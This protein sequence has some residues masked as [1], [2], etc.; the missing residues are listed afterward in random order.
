MLRLPALCLTL[1]LSFAS[2]V[3]S[4][5]ILSMEDK[6]AA[7]RKSLVD[8]ALEGPTRVTATQ[9][10]DGQGV[11]RESSSFRSGVEVRGVR[12]VGYSTDSEGQTSATLKWQD[13]AQ[14]SAAAPTGSC[15][16]AAGGRLQHLLG[17]QWNLSGQFSADER[18]R[19]DQV[20]GYWLGAL[21]DAGASAALW[22]ITPKP[23]TEGRGHYEQALL[24]GGI[25]DLPWLLDLTVVAVAKSAPSAGATGSTS[26][27]V[28]GPN[29]AAPTEIPRTL[30]PF[31]S[32]ATLD[33]ELQMRLLARNQSKPLLVLRTPLTLVE[34]EGNWGVSQL[35]SSART[36]VL[37]LAE[38]AALALY[39][40][41]ACQTVVGEVT[42]ALGK[43]FRINLGAAAGVRVGDTWV[44]ADAG[45]LPQRALEP[46]STTHSVMAKVQYVT[47]H[48]AQLS[49][50]AGPAQKV[51]TRWAAWSA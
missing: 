50:V 40:T 29:A 26:Q 39:K 27:R 33:V 34:Q 44:L 12:V 37:Q 25:D 42:Q 14:A 15:K 22:R 8:V 2:A 10:I 31:Q 35:S 47:E 48:Y 4:A 19:I 18:N 43:Q 7:I 23:R 36:E 16:P 41:M 5:Q 17:W 30:W 46:G 20:R 38:S 1:L 3:A 9:W 21:Q 28:S 49:P 51:Q 6:L 45:S 13:G 32:P 11:L 24:G